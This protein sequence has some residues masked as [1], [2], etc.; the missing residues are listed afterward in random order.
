M[1]FVCGI[2]FVRS[3]ASNAALVNHINFDFLK[4]DGQVP[5]IFVVAVEL[6]SLCSA[7]K[8][9]DPKSYITFVLNE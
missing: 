2:V 7:P 8:I 9:H 6:L 3:V 4:N 5:A 1:H